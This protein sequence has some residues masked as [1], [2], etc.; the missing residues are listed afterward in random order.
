[1]TPEQVAN[2]DNEQPKPEDEHEYREGVGQ[3][4]AESE[5]F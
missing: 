4:I 5:A 2:D 3:E 1:M